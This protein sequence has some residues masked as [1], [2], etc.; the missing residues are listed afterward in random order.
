MV[1]PSAEQSI[2]ST[3]SQPVV[4]A[5]SNNG[6]SAPVSGSVATVPSPF[7]CLYFPMRA[8]QCSTKSSQS[9]GSP[10]DHTAS[11]WTTYCTTWGSSLTTSAET[12]SSV[13]S[14]IP[15]SLVNMKTFGSTGLSTMV[16]ACAFSALVL[17]LYERI[18][19][20]QA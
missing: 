20:S 15:A 17:L 1:L 18:S 5:E 14:S 16:L 7:F 13:F 19:C 11:G 9:I 10:S 6:N 2:D 3:W 12:M 8:A 4:P